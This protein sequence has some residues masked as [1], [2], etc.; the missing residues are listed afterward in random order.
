MRKIEEKSQP[1]DR[2]N[3]RPNVDFPHFGGGDPY[4]RSG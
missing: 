3:S 4:K 1:Y 2:G